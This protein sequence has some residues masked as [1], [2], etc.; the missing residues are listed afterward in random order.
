MRTEETMKHVHSR[1]QLSNIYS[2]WL[3]SQLTLLNVSEAMLLATY[4]LV[5]L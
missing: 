2:V 3:A 5:L 1:Q 4:V